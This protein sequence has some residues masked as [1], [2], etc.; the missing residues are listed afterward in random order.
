MAVL[1]G[2]E[3]DNLPDSAFA[4]IEPGGS[5]DASGRTTPRSKRHFPIHDAAHVRNALA[6][7][8]QGAEFSDQAGPK[9]RAKAKSMGIGDGDGEEHNSAPT[10]D[11]IEVRVSSTYK[12]LK[13][14]VE[15]RDLGSE[16]K[17]IGGY[18]GVF[19]PKHSQNLGGFIEKLMPSALDEM[20]AAG[21][22]DVICRFNHDTNMILGTTAADTL[23]IR[24]DGIGLDYM[25]KPPDSRRD[26]V[27]LVER[28]DIRHS[29]F[30][31]KCAE[32]RWTVTDQNYPCR[33]LHSI[34]LIDTSPVLQPGYLDSTAAVRA[35]APAYRSLAMAK[36]V[37]VE[38]VRNM[39]ADNELRS[40]FVKTAPGVI[41]KPK[42]STLFGPQAAAML[43]ERRRDQWDQQD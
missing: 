36:G 39:A 42:I 32:D 30:A 43:L 26:I 15:F 17:W 2:S 10:W 34:L 14:P 11:D 21:W 18:A 22:P 37:P 16:G 7:I 25:V 28:R 40:L 4:Y 1:S 6:R 12:D 3:R 13:S 27:E 24:T 20:R 35:I 19:P 8:A 41:H 5:K 33:E 9:V 31:F 29:S 38:E 23:R